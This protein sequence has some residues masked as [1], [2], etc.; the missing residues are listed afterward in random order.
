MDLIKKLEKKYAEELAQ[1]SKQ[2]KEQ[3]GDN[4]LEALKHIEKIN[5]EKLG[6]SGN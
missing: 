1:I 5:Q 2:R 4:T 6:K 3:F